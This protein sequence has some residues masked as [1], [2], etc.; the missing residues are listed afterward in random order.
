MNKFQKFMTNPDNKHIVWE[1]VR[2]YHPDIETTYVSPYNNKN[3]E[4]D[5]N[6]SI[7]Y[8]R[9]IISGKF[10][11]IPQ[12][13]GNRVSVEIGISF[14]PS[15]YGTGWK[16][17]DFVNEHNKQ[18]FRAWRFA[19]GDSKYDSKSAIWNEETKEFDD[20]NCPDV[21]NIMIKHNVPKPTPKEMMD[22]YYRD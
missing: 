11:Y 21:N 10:N 1:I 12:P 22:Y 2:L 7:K 15:F 19:F 8:D 6:V 9:I 4:S 5:I 3:K 16:L 17:N 20:K 13:I 14:K 18:K